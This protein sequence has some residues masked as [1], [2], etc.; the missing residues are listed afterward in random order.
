MKTIFKTILLAVLSLTVTVSCIR[1]TFP[2]TSYATADQVAAAPGA[3]DLF[4]SAITSTLVG[5]FVYSPGSTRAN[6]FG[7][8]QFFLYW[9]LMGNDLVPPALCN[10][11][12]DSWYCIDHLGPTWANSQYAWTFYYGWIKACNDVINLAGE[13]PDADK[14]P[15]AGQAYFYRAYYYLDLAQM[16][17]QKPCYLDP[18]AETVPVVVE[19][20]SIYDLANNPRATNTEIYAQIISDLDKA[21]KYLAGHQRTDVYTPDVSCVYGLKARAYLLMGEWQQAQDYAKR[22]QAGYTIM[23][24]AAYTSWETGFNTPNNSWMLGVTYKSDDPNIQLNDGDSS[25]GSWMCMEINPTASGCGYAANYGRPI[26]IDRHLYETVPETDFRKNCFVD[27]AIDDMSKRMPWK[28]WPRTPTTVT[29][30]MPPMSRTATSRR[31]AA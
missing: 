12:F 1:E 25:W 17:A 18:N 22:A 15:G 27:F 21:E 3:Y 4:V 5:Q 2:Q 10:G 26:F 6:D 8:P 31:S 19:T 16:F 7:L 20:T 9:D 11:W 23:D 24:K 30:S 28:P 14:A 13:E 29:G